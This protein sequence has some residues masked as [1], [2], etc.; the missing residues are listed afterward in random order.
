MLEYVPSILGEA[1]KGVRPGL[2]K[3]VA[4]KDFPDVPEIER[5]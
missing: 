1:L 3:M 2:A 4:L 5:T